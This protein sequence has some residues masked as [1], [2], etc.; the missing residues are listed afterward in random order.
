MKGNISLSQVLHVTS[1][2]ITIN[3][4]SLCSKGLIYGLRC[5]FGAFGLRG[6]TEE[7]NSGC[8]RSGGL[9]RAAVAGRVPAA[10][11]G[12]PAH[13]SL[14]GSSVGAVAW[15]SPRVVRFSELQGAVSGRVK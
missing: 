6:P 8:C 4:M 14:P 9:G 7:R 5:I 11:R 10:P 13:A 3:D 2:Y 1:W 12:Y 15:G